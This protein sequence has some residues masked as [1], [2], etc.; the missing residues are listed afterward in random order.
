MKFQLPVKGCFLQRCHEINDERE[1]ERERETERVPRKRLRES[2]RSVAKASRLARFNLVKVLSYHF[3][4]VLSHAHGSL[5]RQIGRYCVL[6]GHAETFAVRRAPARVVSLLCQASCSALLVLGMK[7]FHGTAGRKSEK[8]WKV[9]RL[10]SLH[11]FP[12]RYAISTV[13][14]IFYVSD[15]R[16]LSLANFVDL[17]LTLSLYTSND[18]TTWWF[19]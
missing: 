11:G 17:S 6:R 7:A 2:I 1:R 5:L 4:S 19:F 16:P 10:S 9:S 3:N 13:S 14:C 12:D 18:V 8:K 15:S